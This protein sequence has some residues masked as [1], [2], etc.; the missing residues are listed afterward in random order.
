MKSPIIDKAEVAVDFPDK[1]YHGS[2][3]R[4]STFDVRA[5]SHGVHI[6]LDRQ[7]G[8]RRHVGFHLHF[9]LLAGIIEA[10]AKALPKKD[11]MNQG[12]RIALERAVTKLDKSLKRSAGRVKAKK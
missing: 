2:F 10:L 11:V 6:D 8:E 12:Q 3:D 1:Y 9:Y 5:D 4:D 7:A